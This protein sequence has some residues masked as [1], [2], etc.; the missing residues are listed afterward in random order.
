MIWTWRLTCHQGEV[1]AVEEN[2]DG[3]CYS[4]EHPWP[5]ANYNELLILM[6]SFQPVAFCLPRAK[7]PKFL[8]VFYAQYSLVSKL[9]DVALGNTPSG[10]SGILIWKDIPHS[11]IKLDS[12]LN[13]VACRISIPEPISVC[14]VYLPLSSTWNCNNLV[15][16]ISE[17][18]PPVLLMGDF[19]SHSTLW[20]CSS[21][22]QK[23][24]EMEKFLMQSNLC[25]L[26]NKSATHLHPGTGMLSPLD[27]AFL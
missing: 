23:G 22:G 24:L 16:P 13:A 2:L 10:G 26:N 19:N 21:T 7:N 25:L 11:E 1:L 4:M 27:L 8:P 9:Q 14:S 17:L 15:S 18:P 12:P 20:G 3:Q 6:Q 5:W